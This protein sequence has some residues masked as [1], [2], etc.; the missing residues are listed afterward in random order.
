MPV[1]VSPGCT[2]YRAAGVAAVT[3]GVAGLAGVA[4]VV[5]VMARVRAFWAGVAWAGV[6]V[7]RGVRVLAGTGWAILVR[8]V[9]MM[10]GARRVQASTTHADVHMRM[11][12][13]LS[14]RG[15]SAR[16]LRAWR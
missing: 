10:T 12:V 4:G 8:P 5:V 11:G 2:A 1:R 13:S 9:I 3:V 15:G 6:L 7:V 16:P 14:F